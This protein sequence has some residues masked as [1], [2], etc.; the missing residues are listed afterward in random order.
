[1]DTS[2][3]PASQDWG[4]GWRGG[5]GRIISRQMD[6]HAEIAACLPMG[7]SQATRRRAFT[8][9]SSVPHAARRAFAACKTPLAKPGEHPQR[10]LEGFSSILQA[11]AFAG[12]KGLRPPGSATWISMSG[13]GEPFA[14][15][16]VDR[17]VHSRQDRR[18]AIVA[19]MR[20]SPGAR[21]YPEVRAVALSRSC[22]TQGLR[23]PLGNR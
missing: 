17:S 3:L 2:S 6:F 14:E 10:H 11:D 15:R 20:K 23:H 7:T 4:G 22:P 5:L 9:S 8:R 12:F 19:T 21:E 13:L 16:D 18:C 1:M